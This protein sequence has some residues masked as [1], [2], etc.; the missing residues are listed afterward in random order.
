ML[1]SSVGLGGG[2]SYTA[3][4][5]I[6]G[7]NYELIP[8]ISLALNLA[9]TF[10]GMITFWRGGHLKFKLIA[11]FLVASIP[12]SYVGGA[13]HLAERVFFWLLLVTLAFVAARLYLFDDFRFRFR[14]S[15]EQRLVFSLALGGLLGFVAGAVG[16]GGGIYLVPV[17][18]LFGLASEK[19]AA[20]A[21]AV[22]VWVNSAAGLI[23]RVQRGAFSGSLL[24]PML[25]AVV[26][27]GAVGSHLGARRFKPRTVQRTLGIVMLL[28]I[29]YLLRKLI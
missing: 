12:M 6:F 27:G 22:F 18:I 15:P 29:F 4:M 24:V 23:S 11:P 2:S 13:L 16:I 9:V 5:A 26:L 3:L 8:T 17:L 14:L 20:A 21:G 28:A 1:Y 10:I 7:V 19:E 25:G